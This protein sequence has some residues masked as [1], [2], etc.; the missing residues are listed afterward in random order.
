MPAVAC[1][2]NRRGA[3]H[4][5]SIFNSERR[6]SNVSLSHAVRG[7]S[8]RLDLLHGNGRRLN[9]Q[10]QVRSSR[11]AGRPSRRLTMEGPLC[12]E[13]PFAYPMAFAL[14]AVFAQAPAPVSNAGVVVRHRRRVLRLTG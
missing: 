1:S 4:M 7:D 13:R 14:A 8:G 5:P 3:S 9:A 10:M 11:F 2:W 6:W 12:K